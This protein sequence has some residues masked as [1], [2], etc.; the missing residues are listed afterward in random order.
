MLNTKNERELAYITKIEEIRALDGYDRV[1]YARIGAGW[2]VVVRKDQFHVG[3]LAIYF[4]VDSRVPEREPFMFLEN[5]HF[6]IK[7]QKMCKVVSQG[8]LMSFEDFCAADGTMPS[9]M[10]EVEVA[11]QQGTAEGMFLTN[12]LGVTYADPEDNARKELPSVEKASYKRFCA[13]PFGKWVMRAKW[14]RNLVMVVMGQKPRNKSKWPSWVQKTDEERVQNMPWLFPQCETKWIA[15]EKIDGTSTT[16]TMKN[17]LR[18]K[19][20]VCSR[21]VVFDKPNGKSNIYLKIAETYHMDQV[22]RQMLRDFQRQYGEV[23]RF[24]TIQGET[25][26]A[27][28]QRREYGM[29]DIDMCVFNIII[30]LKNRMIRLNP[31]SG[32]LVAERYGL[33]FVPVVDVDLTLPA[34]CDEVIAMAHGESRIDG[35]LREGLVFRS[36]DGVQSFKAVDPAF[37]LKY[38]C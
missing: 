24:V 17:G 23:V 3:D 12:A 33:N 14:R 13:S 10:K 28:V 35:G 32:T 7:T 34:T 20:L 38:H 4:E 5:K 18:K 22:L 36:T 15:T 25:Y 27:G 37:L 8:L 6:R 30:G 16:F 21:N 9:W 1:E 11:R 26:G 31:M 29:K 2:W 19:L